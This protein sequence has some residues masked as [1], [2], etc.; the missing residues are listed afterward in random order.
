MLSYT[1]TLALPGAAGERATGARSTVVARCRQSVTYGPPSTAAD[2]RVCDVVVDLVGAVEIDGTVPPTEGSE[3]LTAERVRLLL[4]HVQAPV[5][6]TTAAS[7][8]APS[9]APTAGLVAVAFFASGDDVR[10]SGP[11]VAGRAHEMKAF[12]LDQPDGWKTWAS[13]NVPAAEMEAAGLYTIAS[14]FGARALAVLM[15][16]DS[17]VTHESLSAAE[18]QTGFADMVHAA[19]DAAIE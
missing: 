11:V 16:S 10:I 19:L 14:R 1:G 12:G 18:R 2:A 3:R 17:L 7:A 6:P 8:V 5:K 13:P 9:R 15:V 4:R